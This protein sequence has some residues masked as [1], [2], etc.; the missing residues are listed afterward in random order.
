MAVTG[1]ELEVVEPWNGRDRIVVWID[2]CR[3]DRRYLRRTFSEKLRFWLGGLMPPMMVHGGDWDRR[4]GPRTAHQTDG[5]LEEL[6]RA[7]VVPERTDLYARLL[8]AAQ[9]GQPIRRRGKVLADESAI[10][11]FFV[12]YVSLFE[13]MRAEGYRRGA[14]KDEPGVAIAR[15]APTRALRR[16][17]HDPLVFCLRRPLAFSSALAVP[18]GVAP[19]HNRTRSCSSARLAG[20]RNPSRRISQQLAGQDARSRPRPR[21]RPA[22]RSAGL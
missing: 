2:P 16:P 1:S 17:A 13:S 19:P 11:E 6:Y 20:H 7:D 12:D 18:G 14:G 10:S 21:K 4:V 9:A 22:R 5:L 15:S 3:V 8:N